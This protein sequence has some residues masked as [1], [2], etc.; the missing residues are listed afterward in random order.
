VIN[1]SSFIGF[2]GRRTPDR[3]A[4][5][6]AGQDLS[7]AEF[8]RRIRK[9]AGWLVSRGIKP[10]G[11]VAVLM[12]N[13]TAFLELVFATSHIGAVFLPINYR[14]SADEVGYIIG[15]SG[16]QLLIADEELAAIA[17]GGAPV[18]LLDEAAQANATR[19]APDVAPAPVHPRQ[20][21]DLMRLMYTSGTTDRP[22]G[23]M[24]SYE[25]MY[26][27]SADQTLVLGLNADTRL[28]VVGPL[29]HV[30]AL[31][32]P[33]IAV[34]WHGGLLSI[35]RNFEPDAALAAIESEKLNAAWF[36]PVMT[37]A[38]LAHPDAKRYDVSSLQ[39]AI[40]GGE[41]TPEARIRAFSG[42][43]KQARY[44]DAYGLTETVGGDT[45]MEAGRE[46]EKIG[47]TGRAIAH[48]DVEIRDE[49]GKC[50]PP[51][52]DGEICL[53]GPKVTKGYWKD[54]AKTAAAF[55]GDWFRTGDIGHLD[56]EG[57]LY[58]TDRKKDMIISGG[59]N[60]ASS[61]VERVI[62]ELAVVRECAVIGLPDPRWG[63]KPVAVVVL[64]DKA[65]LDLAALAQHCRSRLAGF[66]VP[67]ELVIRDSLPRNPS[68]KVLKRVLRTE[69]EIR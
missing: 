61:E 17:T 28:L 56:A 22:K 3:V 39:W 32:L 33:G 8:D 25:N 65:S 51:G 50:L 40:G 54:P 23:V 53:R 11:V 37:T 12:K 36:A 69:L 4:L 45:F 34:L 31:D 55:F 58:L 9:V 43:F 20:P 21:C 42:V 19:L 14:L 16:A 6:Y 13:S 57:F 49:L 1:L 7:Y 68:G 2:H 18:V 35:Q 30:G 24:L 64:A 26:W 46:I 62:Y 47:S 63:E 48:V 59:E 41:K 10:D 15:N 67:R 27:K 29:Y 38:L 60:I 66:K 5:T 44:I 52:E